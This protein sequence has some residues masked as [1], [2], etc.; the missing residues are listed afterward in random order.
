MTVKVSLEENF[1]NWEISVIEYKVE[2]IFT[3]RKFSLI[4]LML[5]ISEKFLQ[6]KISSTLYS[7]TEISQFV[8]FSSSENVENRKLV[9]ISSREIFLLYNIPWTIWL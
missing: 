3:R 8:K 2:E 1:T 6:V 5:S 7:I 4:S 9:K